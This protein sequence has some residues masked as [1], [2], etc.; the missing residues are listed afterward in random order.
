M[1]LIKKFVLH[2]Y[3]D[4]L[5]RNSVYL[6]LS[7][8]IM[9]GLGFVF[10]LVVARFYSKTEIGLTTA[11]FSATALISS[12]SILGF[13]NSIIKFLPKSENKARD[14]Y[15]AY[16]STTVVSLICALIYL[17]FIRSFSP[18][19]VFLRQNPIIAV[20][21]A[22]FVVLNGVGALLDS[23]FI[24][25]KTS[26]LV[27]IKSIVFSVV[28]LCLPLLL[29][30]LDGHGIF[31][32]IVISS[33]I[34][35]GLGIGVLF[36]RELLRLNVGFS[37]EFIRK[38]F[39]FSFANYIASF[40]GIFPSNGLNLIVLSYL[41]AESSAI[42]YMCLMVVGLIHIIPKS[43]SQSLFA[44]GSHSEEGLRKLVNRAVLVV[45]GLIIPTVIVAILFGK[46]VLLAFGSS[47]ASDGAT[48]LSYLALGAIFTSFNYMGD[49]LLNIKH[50]MKAYIGMNV[51]NA[52]TLLALSL[53]FVAQGL[54]GIGKA[55][56]F[57][58]V[59]TCVL[60]FVLYL[61]YENRKKITK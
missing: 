12:I 25:E 46:Y 50:M 21:F 19:L 3:N 57:T 20:S 37:V 45:M 39:R 23:T 53:A 15:T 47:Y 41:G 48:L 35:I 6:M 30:G 61:V 60:Y 7:T 43:V 49:T 28:K 32:A 36:K 44:E 34:S 8:A 5:F 9:A 29:L 2:F 14:L 4:S 22:L 16:F 26:S 31:Y 56:F 1:N 52:M 10:W 17:I 13:N 59:L 38:V 24:A 58:Q 33:L 54:N 42:F 18:E 27:L 11:I 51:I 40:F 55:W